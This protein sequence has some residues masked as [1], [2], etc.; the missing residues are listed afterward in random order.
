MAAKNEERRQKD[1]CRRHQYHKEENV[2][3]PSGSDM[4]KNTWGRSQADQRNRPT[5]GDPPIKKQCYVCNSPELLMKDY[6]ARPSESTGSNTGNSQRRP[7]NTRQG[8]NRRGESTRVSVVSADLETET[9]MNLQCEN[10]LGLLFSDSDIDTEV[11][12]IRVSDEGSKSQCAHVEVQRV[13]AYGIIDTATDITIIGG[14]LF[15]H[16]TAQE[17]RSQAA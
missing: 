7:T 11:K 5:P 1:L 4:Y 17:E 9:S 12:V 14:R 15:N 13:Q 3:P 10:L 2:M 6:H 16:S 8:P